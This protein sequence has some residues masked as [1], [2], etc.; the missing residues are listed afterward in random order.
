MKCYCGKE[1]NQEGKYWVCPDTLMCGRKLPTRIEKIRQGYDSDSIRV[2][3]VTEKPD[4]TWLWIM[5]GISTVVGLLIM[6]SFMS[7]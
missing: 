3:V 4:L 6:L 1:M 2:Q 5:Y 7:I